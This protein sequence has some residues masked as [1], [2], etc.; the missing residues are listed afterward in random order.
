MSTG[1][2]Q[3]CSEWAVLLAANPDELTPADR[4]ALASH[5]V[6]CQECPAVLAQYQHL[7]SSL[8]RLPRP[9]PLADLPEGLLRLWEEDDRQRRS[10]GFPLLQRKGKNSMQINNKSDVLSPSP[11]RLPEK[12]RSRRV[13]GTL[14]AL[15]AVLVVGLLTTALVLSR[16]QAHPNTPANGKTPTVP[17]STPV[18]FGNTWMVPQGLAELDGE[19]VIAPSNPQV[20]YRITVSDTS[21]VPLKLFRSRDGG[22]NW[23]SLSFPATPGLIGDT[24]IAVSPLNAQTVVLQLALN[25]GDCPAAQAQNGG[26]LAAF[27]PGPSVCYAHYVSVDGGDHWSTL[28]LPNAA[29]FAGAEQL[30]PM[31]GVYSPLAFLRAQGSRLY[32]EYGVDTNEVGLITSTDGG[33]TWGLAMQAVIG[34]NLVMCDALPVPDSSEVFAIAEATSC[35]G[36]GPLQVWKSTDAGATWTMV[37]TLSGTGEQGMAV[38]SQG[39]AAHPLLYVNVASDSSLAG[40]LMASSDEGATWVK[41]PT[42]GIPAG[43]QQQTGP[44]GALSDGSVL[45][46]FGA[47]DNSAQ[48][49]LYR[50]KAGDAAWQ[51]V[52]PSFGGSPDYVLVADG[53]FW[54]VTVRGQGEFTLQ[55]LGN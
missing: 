43:L 39:G 41:A 31:G 19:P 47:V 49:T 55:R 6:S 18:V 27:G 42:Q 44:L 1:I 3:P 22:A 14:S 5:L 30:F 11:A 38:A 36:G 23:Q 8:Q 4:T 35:Q 9:A 10:S 52:G 53:T 25:G 40:D 17:T 45:V 33:L 2:P 15:A 54:L 37:N 7:D 26:P 48:M 21:A 13:I 16:L 32:A 29:A 20:L 34:Q 46:A 28:H 12:R 50:W 51:Q 24:L